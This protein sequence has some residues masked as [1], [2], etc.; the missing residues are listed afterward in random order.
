MLIPGKNVVF[1]Y[2]FIFSD[3]EFKKEFFQVHCVMLCKDVGISAGLI[4]HTLV[5]IYPHIGRLSSLVS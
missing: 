3:T 5:D 2:I 4:Q 1:I